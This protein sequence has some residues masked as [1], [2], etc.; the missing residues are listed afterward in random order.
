MVQRDQRHLC[1]TRT[2]VR[3]LAPHSGLKGPMLPLLWH[4][5]PGLGTPYATGWQKIHTHTHAHTLAS[6]AGK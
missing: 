2:Q 4:S 6:V 3:S 1:S 5:F